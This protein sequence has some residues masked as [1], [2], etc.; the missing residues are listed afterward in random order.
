MG[1]NSITCAN[2]DC[3]QIFLINPPPNKTPTHPSNQPAQAAETGIICQKH[4]E[5]AVSERKYSETNQIMQN[6]AL[7]SPNFLSPCSLTSSLPYP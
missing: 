2:V 4:L 6:H 7:V 1:K 3:S 5:E